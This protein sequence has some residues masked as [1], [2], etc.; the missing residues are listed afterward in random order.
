MTPMPEMDGLT[1]PSPPPPARRRGVVEGTIG[2]AVIGGL[3]LMALRALA[4]NVF[5]PLIHLEEFEPE[6][7]MEAAYDGF[8]QG[9]LIGAVV[10]AMAGA[11]ARGV[12][13]AIDLLRGRG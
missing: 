6:S 13:S 11:V 9:I 2:G 12:N 4:F 10:G 3:C 1:D 8:I 7:T 5:D